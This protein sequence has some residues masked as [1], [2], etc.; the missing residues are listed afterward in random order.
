MRAVDFFCG[1]GGMTYGFRQAGIKVLAGIDNDIHCKETYEINNK[2]SIFI[3]K[4]ITKFNEEELMEYIDIE[5]NDDDMV[6]IG[7]SPC[8]Y[9]TKIQT[10]KMKSKSSKNLLNDFLRFIRYYKPGYFIIENVP[11]LFNKK[12]ENVLSGFID[13]VTKEGYHVDYDII[14]SNEYG[15]PQTR[16]RFLLIASRLSEIELPEAEDNYE[17]TVRNY[18]GDKKVFP[19]IPAG[20]KDDTD[21]IHTTCSLSEKNLIRIKM[22]EHNGGIRM[23]WKDNPTL[24]IPTYQ[25]NDK[26]FRNIYGRIFWDKPA[27]TITTKFHSF[28]NGRFGHPDEDRALSLREGATLQTF[29]LTYKFEGSSICSISKQIGNAVPPE[30]AKRIGLHLIWSHNNAII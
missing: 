10:N 22:T 8:Q 13:T 11:G 17:L 15:V 28:S 14:Y 19:S 16:R 29:P 3:L 24:Q 23:S 7:C 20:H 27:P 9:W 26:S 2:D 18:I 21:F 5:K 30:L 4:D 25:N 1:A 6:F 12:N